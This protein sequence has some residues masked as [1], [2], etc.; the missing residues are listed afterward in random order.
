VLS[1]SS[2]V[3]QQGLAAVQMSFGWNTEAVSAMGYPMVFDRKR[4]EPSGMDSMPDHAYLQVS[5][6]VGNQQARSQPRLWESAGCR[7]ESDGAYQHSGT[8]SAHARSFVARSHP[9]RSAAPPSRLEPSRGLS[10]AGPHNAQRHPNSL[11]G[12][13]VAF[14]VLFTL[15]FA[16]PSASEECAAG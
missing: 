5:G 16:E 11:G 14:R 15:L 7:F 8:T 9:P 12:L 13:A 10:S 6:Q 2:G 1:T 4:R 3:S